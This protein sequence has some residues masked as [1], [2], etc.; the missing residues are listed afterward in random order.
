[1]IR[2]IIRTRDLRNLWEELRSRKM[3]RIYS[4]PPTE[5]ETGP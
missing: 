5:R 3:L 4:R 2:L 1:M